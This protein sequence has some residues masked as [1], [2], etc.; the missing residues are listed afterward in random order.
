VECKHP[1]LRVWPGRNA[2]RE[3]GRLTESP[4]YTQ[5]LRCLGH[6]VLHNPGT[7]LPLPSGA[8]RSRATVMCMLFWLLQQALNTVE[9]SGACFAIHSRPIDICPDGVVSTSRWQAR[10]NPSCTPLPTAVAAQDADLIMLSLATHE[11]HFSILRE[12]IQPPQAVRFSERRSR[13]LGSAVA[14]LGM[15]GI[16]GLCLICTAHWSS[17][18]GGES[19]G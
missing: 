13:I 15:V 17:T 6:E 2:A 7:L 16:I 3:G 12:V 18:T 14:C 1:A 10:L 9:S 8:S 19:L 11:P 4:G 5:G